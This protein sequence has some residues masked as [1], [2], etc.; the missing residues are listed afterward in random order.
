MVFLRSWLHEHSSTQRI[1]ANLQLQDS[2]EHFLVFEVL[3]AH[4]E[5]RGVD[6]DCVGEGAARFSRETRGVIGT[7]MMIGGVD[8]LSR[9]TSP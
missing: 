5:E 1:L 3:H 8:G 6:D 2:P 9:T 4:V 7:D